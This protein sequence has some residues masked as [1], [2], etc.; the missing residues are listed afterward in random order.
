MKKI[1]KNR[2]AGKFFRSAEKSAEGIADGVIEPKSTLVV[3]VSGGPDS[4]YLLHELLKMKEDLKLKIII[5][6]VNHALRGRE[7]DADERFVRELAQ[8]NG[9]LFASKRLKKLPKGNLEELCREERYKFLEEVRKKHAA[10]MILT[11]HHLNDNI[12]TVLFNFL[13]GSSVQGLA[14]MAMFDP[15]RN[16]LR[17]L[18][19][20][21]KEEILASLKK[22]R[23]P[24]RTDSSNKNT[25]FSRNLLRRKVIPLLKKINPNLEQTLSENITHFGLLKEFLNEQAASWLR[26]N[27]SKGKISHEAFLT[28]PLVLQKNVVG[29]LYRQAYGSSRKL[30]QRHM[31]EIM[32]MLG[33]KKSNR[34]KEFG[35]AWNICILKNDN[36]RTIEIRRKR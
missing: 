32:K 30:N 14:G 31:S 21:S 11:A 35:D 28:L 16:L 25:A 9:L 27:G 5:A 15:G 19:N 8:K 20:I 22:N 36:F 2:P 1:T 13:R 7:S 26:D 12:E 18:L 23:I 10:D 34:E 33:E 3:G 24:Y 4:V 29:K 17:P 6:H